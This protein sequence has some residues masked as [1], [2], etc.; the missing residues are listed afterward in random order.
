MSD[1][2]EFTLPSGGPFDGAVEDHLFRALV[3]AVL[4]HG[5][6]SGAERPTFRIHGEGVQG[7]Y[8]HAVGVK[9][10]ERSGPQEESHLVDGTC[11]VSGVG[12]E[13]V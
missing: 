9:R 10:N 1:E 5:Q 13:A 12:D 2:D 11:V 8:G 3:E 6:A 7:G 4:A